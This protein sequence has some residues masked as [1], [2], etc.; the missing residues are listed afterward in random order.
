MQSYRVIRSVGF[1]Q[2]KGVNTLFLGIPGLFLVLGFLAFLLGAIS[3]EKVFPIFSSFM[4]IEPETF[5][6][7]STPFTLL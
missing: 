4:G 2:S 6:P 3:G 1:T 5:L 7:V